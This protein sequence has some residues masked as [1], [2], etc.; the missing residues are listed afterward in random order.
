MARYLTSFIE[1]DLKSKIVLLGGP[2]QVGKTSLALEILG[3]PHDAPKEHPAYFNWDIASDRPKVR[4]LRLPAH[5]KLIVLDEIHKYARWRNLLKG[6]YDKYRASRQ[7]LVT[8]S[9][10]LDHYRKG[11]DSLQGRHHF[12]RLHPYSLLELDSEAKA[13]TLGG[14]LEYGGFPEPLFEASETHWR[15]WSL[16]RN[17]LILRDDLKDLERV[18]EVS[19]VE[20]LVDALP[21]R[22]G[23]PLSVQ[24]LREDLEVAHDTVERWL[25]ILE[26][27][28]YC[29]RISPYGSPKIK[30]VKKE[31]KLYLWDWS[32][33]KGDP[34]ARFE[35]LV[36]CQLLKYC[37]F[38]QD[39]Q[40]HL[41]D[42]RYVRDTEKREID[43][44]VLQ[45]R[46]PLF[47]VECKVSEKSVNEFARYLR[48]RTSIPKFYQVHLG[49][50]DFGD[51]ETDVRVLPFGRFCR[52][53]ELP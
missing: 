1:K 14:L 32:V 41:M 21:S 28:Y 48:T 16:E 33:L 22:V 23:S 4:E 40:G 43:F 3:L 15:R 49:K 6:L 42:L 19:L 18:R 37:H 2:R 5:E 38:K 25:T 12:Y 30:A 50:A 53:L 26:N 45:D 35:N 11:G 10:R 34:G 52:E 31:K 44:V 17:Q 7:F 29:F 27:L 8:G 20:M 24:S 13:S 36:A 47:A 46:K 39:T 51:A 9:A